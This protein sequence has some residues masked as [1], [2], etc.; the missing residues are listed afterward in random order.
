MKNGTIFSKTRLIP[1]YNWDYTA[2]TLFQAIA[3]TIFPADKSDSNLSSLFS[4]NHF[5]TTSGRL[6]LFT[7]LQSLGLEKGSKIGVPLFC[8]PVVFDAIIQAGFIPRF[9]DISPETYTISIDDVKKKRNELS[10]IIAVHMFG[11]SV[12]MDALREAAGRIWVIEDCAQ[13]LYSTYKGILT[14]NI[15]DVSFFS[16]RSGKNLSVGEG[17][18]IISKKPEL[19]ATLRKIVSSLPE[20]KMIASLLHF[21]ATWVKSTLYQRPWYGTIGYPIGIRLDKKLNLTA[22]TGFTMRSVSPG[23]SALIRKR[24]RSFKQ[25]ILR[26]RENG[27]FYLKT[28]KNTSLIFPFEKPYCESNYY[29]FAIRTHSNEAR[30]RFA[31]HLRAHCIDA[32]K[33]LDDISNEAKEKYGYANDCPIAE[34]CSQTVVTVPVYYTLSNSDKAKIIDA[35]NSFTG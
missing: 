6:S 13:S 29:Q 31:E 3:A 27:L 18:V 26:Q 5:Y 8:C 32:A 28:M 10:A 16:F 25:K 35:V 11:H 7:I 2:T 20:W 21:G 30:N 19:S 24:I 12:D 1:R 23:D 4:G 34:Q 9:I 15:A 14:G 17:S 22:K 33:Y